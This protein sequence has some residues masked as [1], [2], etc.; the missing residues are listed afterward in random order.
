MFHR[1]GQIGRTLLSAV[2]ILAG[3]GLIGAAGLSLKTSYRLVK[4]GESAQGKATGRSGFA[5]I[6]PE[7]EFGLPNGGKV[8]FRQGG[9]VFGLKAA[10]P[11][12]ILYLPADPAGSA[13]VSTFGGIWGSAVFLAAIGL[14]VLLVGTKSGEDI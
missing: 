2:L 13:S 14:V 1:H 7:I 9:I 12:G 3:L 5:G 8:G 11:V 10:Q 4:Q 6:H